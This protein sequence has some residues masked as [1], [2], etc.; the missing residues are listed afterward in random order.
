MSMTNRDLSAILGEFNSE[1]PLESAT[2]LPA[3]WYT[4]PLV[5]ERELETVF[6]ASWQAIV[7]AYSLSNRGEFATGE[8]GRLPVVVSRD[9]K[10]TLHAFANVCRHRAALVACGAGNAER[11]TCPYHGWQ[12]G[13]DG[14]LLSAPEL[15][16]VCEFDRNTQGLA[17][18]AVEQVGPLLF[19]NSSQKGTAPGGPP[20]SERWAP[21]WKRLEATGWQS[22]QLARV[23]RYSLNCNWKVFVDNYLDGGYHVAAVHPGLAGLLELDSYKTEVF[24]DYS[25]Q[26]CG[27]AS[28]RIGSEAIYAYLYPNFMINRYG[29]AMDVNLVLPRGA[30]ACEVV[31]AFYF[32]PDV[33]ADSARVDAAIASS[34]QVQQEDIGICESGLA[35]GGY[36]PG[37]YSVF[38]QGAERAFHVRLAKQLAGELAGDFAG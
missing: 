9:E 31:F 26:S 23:V 1:K 33:L 35:S 18:L 7:A 21:L 14:R 25:I 36:I 34:D 5:A 22:L 15:G 37:R 24:E 3:S 19:A 20:P 6:H 10:N 38:R 13:L 29:D 8:M 27:G 2:A 28:G 4:S 11:F 30:S 12:Y 16:G 32:T 17:S